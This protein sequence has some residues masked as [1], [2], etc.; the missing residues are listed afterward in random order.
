MYSFSIGAGAFEREILLLSIELYLVA[1]LGNQ[2]K[3]GLLRCQKVF[4]VTVGVQDT[5][6]CIRGLRLVY[7]NRV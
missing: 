7:F 3:Q 4:V 6:P 2:V 1:G 5:D